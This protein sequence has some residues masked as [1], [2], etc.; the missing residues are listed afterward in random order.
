MRGMR[1]LPSKR[2]L[3]LRARLTLSF[4][5]GALLL[6][7]ILSLTAWGLTRENLIKERD[8]SARARALLNAETVSKELG[9]PKV[10]FEKLISSLPTPEGAQ[11]IILYQGR[12]HAV[13]PS[14]FGSNDL[15]V[16]L[17]DLVASGKAATMRFYAKDGQPYL[18]I[19][20]PIPSNSATYYEAVP[21]RDV[22]KALDGLAISL[23]GASAVTTLAGGL[24]GFWISRRALAP[25]TKVGTAAEAI[26]GGR[27]DT[28]L[29]VSGDPDL[30]TLTQSFNKMVEALESRIERDARFA[31]EVSHE[32]RSPLMT[33]SASIEV[34]DNTREGMSDRAQ[35]ALGLM[36]ADVERFQQ[37]VEDLLEIS[38]FDVGAITLHLEEVLAVD[39]IIQ[40]MGAAGASG[41]KVIYDED[42]GDAVVLLDKRRFVRVIANLLDNANKYAGG[43]TSIQIALGD[44]EPDD[45]GLTHEV[46]RIAVE[47]AGHGVPADER[48]LIF[49]RFSRGGG[50]GNRG[51]DSGVGLGLA[52]VAEHVRL[53]GGSVWVEERTDRRA[54]ARFVIELPTVPESESAISEEPVAV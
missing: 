36:K 52:L 16:P 25:L 19:G 12:T 29:E 6:S 33:L 38:R 1:F 35:T 8:D 40:A 17:R 41:T 14:T 5:L 46:V 26:A 47:D 44:S 21:L 10:D 43:A 4:G 30:D 32:L 20:I 2:I 31:S 22:E 37:L 42:V 27:L 13:N 24:F 50:G 53:H 15:P 49:D 45:V 11:P 28:R 51:A 3:G 34:L 39:F 48:E 9:L 7:A 18:A 54:G 23:L